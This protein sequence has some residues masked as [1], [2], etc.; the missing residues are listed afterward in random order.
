MDKKHM[1]RQYCIRIGALADERLKQVAE[2]FDMKPSTYVKAVIYKDLGIF[3]EPLDRRKSRH[4][5][6]HNQEDWEL[7]EQ[8]SEES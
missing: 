4:R 7:H 2:M 3:N 8:F 5:R 1:R 6:E